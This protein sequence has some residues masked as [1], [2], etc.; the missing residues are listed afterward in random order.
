MQPESR[1]Q[2]QTIEWSCLGMHGPRISLL[3]SFPPPLD[4]GADTQG[5]SLSAFY[6]F[7]AIIKMSM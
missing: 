5:T 2:N 7:R 6:T 3:S 4:P 1:E